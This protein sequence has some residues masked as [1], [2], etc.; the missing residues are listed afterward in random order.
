MLGTQYK[1]IAYLIVVVEITLLS[2][3]VAD[4]VSEVVLDILNGAVEAIASTEDLL[5]K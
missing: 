1:L 4:A 3:V 2:A 5:K